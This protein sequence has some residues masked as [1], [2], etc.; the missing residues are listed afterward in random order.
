MSDME[1]RQELLAVAARHEQELEQ[2]LVDVKQA[3]RRP[4]AIAERIAAN[5]APW[6]IGGLLI[7]LWLGSRSGRG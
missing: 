3:V 4:F 6:L 1:T 7:G 2:A 5:P